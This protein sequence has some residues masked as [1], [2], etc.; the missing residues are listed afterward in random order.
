MSALR[1]MFLLSSIAIGLVGFSDRFSFKKR[2][3]VKIFAIIVLCMAII[4]GHSSTNIF[5]QIHLNHMNSDTLTPSDK[6]ILEQSRIF[7]FFSYTFSGVLVI[8]IATL[9]A[10]KMKRSNIRQLSNL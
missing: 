10:R 1:N 2:Q 3:L 5:K 6:I 7:P 9:L 8:L 4:I